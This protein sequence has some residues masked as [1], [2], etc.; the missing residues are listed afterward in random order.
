MGNTAMKCLSLCAVMLMLVIALVIGA[1]DEP[2]DISSLEAASPTDGKESLSKEQLLAFLTGQNADKKQNAAHETQVADLKKQNAAPA[3]KALTTLSK[4]Q[5]LALLTGQTADLKK[6]IV[7]H[8]MQNADLKKQNAALKA[9]LDEASRLAAAKND[10]L[11]EQTFMQE[12]F[13]F[14]GMMTSGKPLAR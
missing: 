14:G 1:A 5:L 8:E 9:R 2:H 13:G 4:E 3:P 11:G 12:R 10:E 6:Q 7:A